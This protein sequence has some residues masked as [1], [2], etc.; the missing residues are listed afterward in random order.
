MYKAVVSNHK[1]KNVPATCAKNTQ[2]RPIDSLWTSPGLM[3]LRCGFLPFHDIYGFQSNHRLV[4]ADICNEDLLGYQP[5]HIYRTP[6]AKARSND[7]EVREKCIQHCIKE[8]GKEDVIND[9]Q[10]L[11][12]F[13]QQQREGKDFREEIICLHRS[14]AIKIEKIQLEVDDTLGKF[15]TGTVSWSPTIQVHR[16]RIDYLHRILRIKTGV[17]TSKNAIKKLSIKFGEYSGNYLTTVACIDKLKSAWKEYQ[18]AKKDAAALRSAFL[19]D[20]I[21]RKAHHKRMSSE[22]MIKMLRKE[23]RSIQEGRDL[24]QIRGRNNKQ[25]VLR[26]K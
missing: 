3:D 20:Q 23:Q 17:L 21:A 1:E 12:Y 6:R 11:T 10:T 13:C 4:W 19:E 24:R 25:P 8:Y 16:D 7:P 2:R 22:D 15:F 26:P 14:L 5:Q 9:S 18:V